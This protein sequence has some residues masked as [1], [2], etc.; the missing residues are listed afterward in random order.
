[1]QAVGGGGGQVR[2]GEGALR[3]RPK[4]LLHRCATLAPAP[5]SAR[6]A[7]CFA[8]LAGRLCQGAARATDSPEYRRAAAAAAA[9]HSLRASEA[10]RSFVVAEPPPAPAATG[11]SGT[12]SEAAVAVAQLG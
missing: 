10:E 8:G 11:G 5:A 2:D 1:M 3:V 7:S 4:R 6:S 9:G 12:V